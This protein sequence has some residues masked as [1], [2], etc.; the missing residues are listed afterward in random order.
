MRERLQSRTSNTPD[1]DVSRSACLLQRKCA[2][3]SG[4]GLTGEC[5]ECSNM[6][7]QR[8]AADLREPASVPPIVDE[9]LRAPGQPLDPQTN[10]VMGRRL[11][12]DFSQVR[13]HSDVR[14]ADSARQVN[15][16][17]YTVGRDV[18]FADGQYAPHT[19]EGQ[20]LVAHE[21]THVVQQHRSPSCG[22]ELKIGAHD[23]SSE[24]EADANAERVSMGR[25]SNVVAVPAGPV[26]HR[27][28]TPG[29]GSGGTSAPIESESEVTLTP[30]LDPNL[31]DL[32]LGILRGEH[33]FRFTPGLSN[34][35]NIFGTPIPGMQPAQLNLFLG[36]ENRC[37][38]AVQS[39]LL[40]MRQ[41]QPAGR[42]APDFARNPTEIE[43][44]GSF[45]AGSW[46]IAPGG[47]VGFTGST[48]DTFAFTLTFTTGVSTEIPD[49]CRPRRETP[50]REPETP[51]PAETPEGGTTPERTPEG[52][53]ETP[54]LP[55]TPT[56]EVPP[57]ARTLPS[58]TLY[59]FYDATILRPE[60]NSTLRSVV[61]LLR[62]VPSL[63][64]MLTGHASL[65][66]TERYNL[67]LS[68][69]RANAM[70]T[71][72]G[73]EGIESSRIH[74]LHF[75]ESAPAVP[76]PDISER[77]LLPSVEGIRNL[78][79]RVEVRFF[80]PT[81]SFGLQLPQLTLPHIGWS[82]PRLLEGIGNE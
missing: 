41:R 46:L 3:G 55:R 59:F 51:E 30:H 57:T 81:G 43:A 76:E 22:G 12:H 75:G 34:P 50:P 63:H 25:P 45:R 7:L 37:N 68:E 78:N 82:R 67:E 74:T 35:L 28:P 6:N 31:I 54:D 8:S 62:T 71:H 42:F 23:S 47:T 38:R 1:A 48:F 15:A 69:R 61:D 10:A 39:V 40:G 5:E 73:L 77:T 9:V 44:S 27:Q 20:R 53:G 79:R 52:G 14:A 60:S 24:H 26:L 49:E 65:E 4:A 33:R 36:Y 29:G 13:V 70:R 21:L 11:G 80:D 2:C 19:H 58:Y 32:S 64:V 56:T 17:A 66:G 72:L 16:L 18:V